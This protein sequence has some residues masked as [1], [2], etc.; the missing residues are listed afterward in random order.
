[1]TGTMTANGRPQRKQL[2]DQL[3]RLDELLNGLADAI[4][5]AVADAVRES[6]GEAVKHAV[7]EA[8]AKTSLPTATVARPSW[9]KRCWDYV[10]KR[11]SRWIQRIQA[12]IKKRVVRVQRW[13]SR[14]GNAW[15]IVRLLAT[16]IRLSHRSSTLPV[17]V[18]IGTGVAGYWLGPI[19]TSIILGMLVSSLVL[20]GSLVQPWMRTM[21]WQTE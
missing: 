13:G 8:L 17:L 2:S 11:V 21:R 5:G 6:L 9:L 15:L 19:L 7:N 18:G 1:M 20:I 3:D 10:G 16:Q 4:P 14:L 12:S